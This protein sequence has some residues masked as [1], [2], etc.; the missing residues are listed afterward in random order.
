MRDSATV[1]SIISSA[2]SLFSLCEL[3]NMKNFTVTKK[4]IIL[5]A[6]IILLAVL[7]VFLLVRGNTRLTTTHFT[8]ESEHLPESFSE[9]RIAHISDLHNTE[10][11]K[12]NH[13][14]LTLLEESRPDII[15]ITGDIIDSRRTNTDVAVKFTASATKIAPVYYV[16]GNHEV[17]LEEMSE[18]LALLEDAGATVLKNEKTSILRGNDEICI[19]GMNDPTVSPSAP[20]DYVD[21]VLESLTLQE[22]RYTVLLAHR[23][24]LFEHYSAHNID[25]VLS[26]HVH[27]GQIRIPF[28]GGIFAP[29]QGFFP[30]YDSGEYSKENTTMIVSRGLGN[31]LFPFRINNPPE[32]AVITLKSK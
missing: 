21:S 19:M 5:S 13:R 30:I 32:V 29:S 6:V 31:S 18:L 8:V 9:F 2:E 20:S 25:L 1:Y 15:V 14:L 3:D 4:N 17:R 27:G 24:E 16:I 12:D 10:F 23:P 22:Q 28:Y 7:V 26:G 11:G